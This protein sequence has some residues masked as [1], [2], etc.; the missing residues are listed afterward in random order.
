MIN[1]N[2]KIGFIGA[3]NMATALISGLVNSGK[4][5]S[6]IMAS[7]PEQAQLETVSSKFGISTSNNNKEVA[8]NCSTILLAVKPNIIEEVL[9]D[10]APFIESDKHL[11]I[12]IAAGVIIDDIQTPLGGRQ[13][14]IRAM[15]NTPASI[16]KGVT[17]LCR[18]SHASTLDTKL[19]EEIFKS[20]GVTCWLEEK[21]LDQYTALI[22]SGPAYVFYVIEA[23]M[24]A[25]K[26]LDIKEEDIKRLLIDMIIGSSELAKISEDEPGIL[27]NKVTSPGGVTQRAIEVLEENK[28]KE[29]IVN[30]I[31][32]ATK[33]SIDLGNK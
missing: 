9:N 20:A 14:I 28:T 30:A 18:N 5:S 24:E 32:E 3:G 22:G 7:S 29:A 21:S 2:K 8:K 1:K 13:R 17:A 11:I 25:S 15:P 31:K 23:L 12:S 27:R 16:Q 33:R 10:I 26:G 4:D 19:A 6:T